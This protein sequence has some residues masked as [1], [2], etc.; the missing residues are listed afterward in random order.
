MAESWSKNKVESNHEG[1]SESSGVCHADCNNNVSFVCGICRSMFCN[2]HISNHNN[3]KNKESKYPIT[4]ASAS[5]SN[6]CRL[7][8]PDAYYNACPF[9]IQS[10][11]DHHINIHSIKCTQESQSYSASI[12]QVAFTLQSSSATQSSLSSIERCC[13]G[14]GEDASGSNHYCSSTS[15]R[16]TTFCM[17]QGSDECHGSSSVCNGCIKKMEE[18]K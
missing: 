15:K 9:C 2:L 6:C 16:I 4:C 18:F 3:C 14:C 11:C 17:P 12:N 1:N 5:N 13:C 7:S 8:S 10:F